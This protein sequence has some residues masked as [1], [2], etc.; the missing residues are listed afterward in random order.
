MRIS[1]GVSSRVKIEL[2]KNEYRLL[3]DLV[4]MANC[5]IHSHHVGERTDVVDY[6]M[7]LQK[8]YSFAGDAG[9]RALV[10]AD[11]ETNEYSPTRYFEETTRAIDLLE[12]Y[13]DDTFWDALISRLAE[14][15]VYEQV[16]EERRDVL[17]IE[18]YWERSEPI[19]EAYYQEFRRHSL[20]RLRLVDN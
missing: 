4:Y 8:L 14:R 18:E 16:E 7:L 12:D 1:E 13:D 17:G 20:D 3:L 5:V 2:T 11:R 6:D 19:E 15:D 10:H 9:C